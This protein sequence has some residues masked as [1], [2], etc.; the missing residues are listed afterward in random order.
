[1]LDLDRRGLR[2]RHCR[3]AGTRLV[4]IHLSS[5]H[6]GGSGIR[7]AVGRCSRADAWV[8]EYILVFGDSDGCGAGHA[9]VVSPQSSRRRRVSG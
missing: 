3:T 1:M 7:T 4:F 9:H 8:E 5:G 2:D 6:H